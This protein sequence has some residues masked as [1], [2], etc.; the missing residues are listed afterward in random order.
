MVLSEAL[1]PFGP[2]PFTARMADGHIQLIEEETA[3]DDHPDT[4]ST[5]FQATFS[6]PLHRTGTFLAG[7]MPCPVGPRNSG[8]SCARTARAPRSI[9]RTAASGDTA[10]RE[11]TGRTGA[12]QE[13][14][15]FGEEFGDGFMVGKWGSER[16]CRGSPEKRIE[17]RNPATR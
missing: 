8:Q 14:N 10:R 1:S 12:V 2:L 17:K 7:E 3:G 13:R 9:P 6:V 11:G 16:H 15:G 5:V 4:G